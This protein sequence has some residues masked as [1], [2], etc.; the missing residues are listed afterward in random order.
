MRARLF[1]TGLLILLL[2]AVHSYG[3]AEEIISEVLVPAEEQNFK[4]LL[5][6]PYPFYNESIGTG[7]GVAAIAQGYVQP[8][9]LAVGSV[10]ASTRGT[11]TSFFMVRNYL[12]PWLDRVI[13]D[14]QISSGKFQEIRSY[15]INSPE[16]PDEL[17]GSNDSSERNYLEADGTDFWFDF[18]IKYL[19]PI[20]YGKESVFPRLQ[21]DNGVFVSG[22]TGGRQYNP[23][24]S[25]RTYIEL[26][27]FYRQL[28][29]KDGVKTNQKTAGI[30]F[31]LTWDNTDFRPNPSAGSYQSVFV[32]RDWGTL[33]S[34]A[35]W[36][37][38]GV[39]I[40]LYLSLGETDTARQRV[41]VFNFWTVNCLTWDS[42]S[43]EDG[44]KVFHRP[45]T[46]KGANLGGLWRLRGYPATR[47]HGRAAVYYC[48]EYRH[49]LDWNPLKKFTLGGRLD[50]DW[51]QLV[52]FSELGRVAQE[53]K[54]D[55]L[56]KDMKFSLGTGA[57]CMV[58]NIIVR[59][60]LGLSKEDA[61]VQLFI[62]H[63]F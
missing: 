43:I 20:G 49:T 23:L 15:T 34:S 5:V 45:P 38:A 63:P 54:I 53:W 37:V 59:A 48:L 7:A 25:G 8:Q 28:D 30:D 11:H 44:E 13:L 39:D 14:P 51:I 22:E 62:G 47:F 46:Y 57:R 6:V 50:V 33:D 29:L 19:L 52:G 61:I 40:T 60:D 12:V 26:T 2:F 32:S 17:P 9:M 21:L 36:T 56:H 27:P 10:L 35:P 1:R 31:A 18:T 4:R 41:L 55:T 3:H 24:K 42:Y 16:F 58:N